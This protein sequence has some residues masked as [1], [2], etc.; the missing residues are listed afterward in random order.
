MTD[1]D[2]EDAI[3]PDLAAYALH[4]LSEGERAR[5]AAHLP[6][7]PECSSELA[8]LEE[9][10][11]ALAFATPLLESPPSVRDALMRRLDEGL[12]AAAAQDRAPD[13]AGSRPW[14]PA[15]RFAWGLSGALAIALV[16]V[17]GFSAVV[18][19]RLSTRID[20]L[21]SRLDAEAAGVAQVSEAVQQIHDDMGE[22]ETE[23]AGALAL[24]QVEQ[25]STLQ[26][27]A[28]ALD[29]KIRDQ[30]WLQ[31]VTSTGLWSSSAWFADEGAAPS[32]QA[33]LVARNGGDSA[34]LTVHGLAPL[35]DGFVYQLWLTRADTGAVAPGATFF[36]DGSGYALVEMQLP[37][38]A[39]GF[40]AASIT[41]EP[42]GG[43]LLPTGAPVLQ[44]SAR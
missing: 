18:A 13:R 11:V 6:G 27:A 2:R 1:R 20:T 43:S 5:V 41:V 30:Q 29:Q 21:N 4:A 7:C 38:A 9:G 19:T 33:E 32:R 42:A 40:A 24:Q 39:T 15:S 25:V 37:G 28:D 10:A 12:K 8:E 16:A 31:Y 44:A 26:Q 34:V 3:R 17:I 14:R 36:V 23:V 22:M 35:P